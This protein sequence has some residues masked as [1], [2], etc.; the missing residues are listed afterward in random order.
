MP[1]NRASQGS[2]EHRHELKG[3]MATSFRKGIS[4]GND[5]FFD[6][7]SLT[8]S[9]CGGH[10]SGLLVIFTMQLVLNSL[11]SGLQILL[12]TLPREMSS[13]VFKSPLKKGYFVG[14]VG[15]FDHQMVQVKLKVLK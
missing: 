8:E 12:Q 4:P 9:M 3:P 2:T 10:F 13:L 11:G 15:Q 5:S 6:Q 7:I 14:H 1:S